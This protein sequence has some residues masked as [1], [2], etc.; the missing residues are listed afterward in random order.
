M[1]HS[2]ETAP[3]LIADAQAALTAAEAQ[4]D[5]ALCIFKLDPTPVNQAKVQVAQER[6][7]D[8]TD[9]VIKALEAAS[10]R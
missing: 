3:D 7:D 1:D 5:P 8:A 6:I 2:N 4:F 10:P 9:R